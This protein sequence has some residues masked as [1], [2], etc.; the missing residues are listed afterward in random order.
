MFRP[1]P[2]RSRG[3]QSRRWVEA[4]CQVAWLSPVSSS[5]APEEIEEWSIIPLTNRITK[6]Q[7]PG[8][9]LFSIV[10]P[11]HL[12]LC[13]RW[14]MMMFSKR[15]VDVSFEEL[16]FS[17]LSLFVSD[18]EL[19]AWVMPC[20]G[21]IAC[22]RG[23]SEALFVCSGP[24]FSSGLIVR[25]WW[26]LLLELLFYLLCFLCCKELVLAILL[27]LWVEM[28][29]VCFAPTIYGFMRSEWRLSGACHRFWCCC[30]P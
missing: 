26:R 5:Q 16:L 28:G 19:V 2:L 7:T 21:S 12:L 8:P 1:N 6:D 25:F 9:S 20:G 27:I 23:A 15:H 30:C 11:L 14:E 4:G 10:R 24:C 29:G 18:D 22:F 13:C 3:R 17:W